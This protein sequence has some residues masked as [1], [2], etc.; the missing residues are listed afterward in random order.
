[1]LRA[2]LKGLLGHKLRFALTALAVTA[3]VAFVV[4]A[5]VLTDNYAMMRVFRGAGYTLHRELEEG[6]YTVDFPLEQTAEAHRYV[7]KGLK[8]G[9]VVITVENT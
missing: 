9:H 5:F 6:V 7:E 1:M 2:T 3:G 8:K 4:G